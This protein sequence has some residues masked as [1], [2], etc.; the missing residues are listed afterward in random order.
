MPLK[1]LIDADHIPV[2]KYELSVVGLLADVVFTKVSGMEVEVAPVDLPDRTKATGGQL[3]TSEL[4]VEVPMHHGSQIAAMELWF[5]EGQD[6]VTITYKKAATL[7]HFSGSGAIS[8]NYS[9]LGVW[10]SKRKLPDLSFED[11]GAMAVAEYTLQV[12]T[13]LPL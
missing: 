9:M 2:N 1:G 13:I 12:D 10:I 8:K 3:G 5:Q 7:T 4:T 11:A 6:P